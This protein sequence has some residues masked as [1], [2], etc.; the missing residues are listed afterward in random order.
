MRI[1]LAIVLMFVFLVGCTN[2]Y[3]VPKPDKLIPQ[4][5]MEN[6]LYDMTIINAAGTYN[7]QRF[8]QTGVDP[9]CHVFEK[10]NIDSAQYA[11]NT[12]YY[13][14]S[15]DEYKELI[16]KV[17][18]RIEK[19]HKAAD[20]AFKEEKR[21]KDSIR[22]ERGKSIRNKRNSLNKSP[23]YRINKLKRSDSIPF[24]TVIE[25]SPLLH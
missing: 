14:A 13:A 9:A 16:D 7:S 24:K 23:G 5:A 15:L 8:S 18:A 4:T 2:V 12:L 11:Q 19:E 21:I 22:T 3:K 20:S 17:K 10:Y 6:I 1:P 25:T